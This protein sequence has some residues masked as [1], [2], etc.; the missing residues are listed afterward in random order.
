MASY[1]DGKSEIVAYILDLARNKYKRLSKTSSFRI[2]DVGACDGKWADLIQGA[3]VYQKKLPAIRMD[4]VEAWAPNADQIVHKYDHVYAMEMQHFPYRKGAYDL[5]LFGDVIEHMT[6]PDA[7]KVL[8]DAL[9]R[10]Q[11]VIVGVP[12]WYP[13]GALYGNPYETHLQPDLDHEI[14][15]ERYPGFELLLNARHDYA[16]YRR[17]R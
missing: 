8:A 10:C 2:L 12:F 15:M 1:D 13:Q 9:D 3:A 5:A 16:Y 7:Q 4:A 17:A 14:F 11:E 6:V